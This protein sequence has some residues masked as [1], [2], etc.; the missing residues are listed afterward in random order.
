[1]KPHCKSSHFAFCVVGVGMALL[2]LTGCQCSRDKY[3]DED[4]YFDFSSG[5]GTDAGTH[6][7]ASGFYEVEVPFEQRDGVKVVSVKLNGIPMDMILDTGCSTNLISLAEANYL[8]NKGV[9]TDEDILGNTISQIA[10]GS[11]KV[12]LV[13]NLSMVEIGNEEDLT[14]RNVQVI[15]DN[16]MKAPLLLGNEILDRVSSVTVDNDRNV[17]I[18]KQ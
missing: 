13:I 1:M 15:V 17:V 16:N 12:G 5:E 9:I 11:L 6:T 3:S 4:V 8:Y 7:D 2:L 18:F 14:F 10:D